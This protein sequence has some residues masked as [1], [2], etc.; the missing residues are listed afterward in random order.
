MGGICGCMGAHNCMIVWVCQRCVFVYWGVP[1]DECM[2]SRE[3]CMVLMGVTEAL[4]V[5]VAADVS[6]AASNAVLV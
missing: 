6:L 1:V 3:I 5:V 4:P 2:H